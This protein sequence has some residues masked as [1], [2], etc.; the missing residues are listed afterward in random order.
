MS[1][2]DKL[3]GQQQRDLL[4]E[5]KTR[6][7]V[8]GKAFLK[9]G[10]LEI[11]IEIYPPGFLM[12]P[13]HAFLTNLARN[14][15]HTTP[16]ASRSRL[17]T[18]V[19]PSQPYLIQ[20]YGKLN[21][22]PTDTA[23]LLAEGRHAFFHKMWREGKVVDVR[24]FFCLT[25]GKK[26]RGKNFTYNESLLNQANIMLS[27]IMARFDELGYFPR[28]LT[29]QDIFE[30]CYAYY[31]PSL[32][33][34]EQK[35]YE[36]TYQVYADKILRE[37][38]SVRAPT[39]KAQ[40]AKSSVNNSYPSVLRVGEFF[41]RLIAM[42]S[43]PDATF[44]GL[45]NLLLQQGI[46]QIMV[47]DFTHLPHAQILGKIKNR[48]SR[49][50]AALDAEA[51]GENIELSEGLARGR[52]MLR[53][54]F[55]TG[56]HI[57]EVTSCVWLMHPDKDILR[58]KATA[59][60]SR[61]ANVPGNPYRLIDSGLLSP[62]LQCAPFSG[63]QYIERVTLVET[64]AAHFFP[65]FG[66]WDGSEK[67]MAMYQTRMGNLVGIDHFD[68]RNKGN[69]ALILGE[70]RSGKSFTMQYHMSEA[71]KDPNIEAVIIDRGLNW[72]RI[73]DVYDG[74]TVKIEPG[75]DTSINPFQLAEGET[76][77]SE[78]QKTLILQ[79]LLAMATDGQL[80]STPNEVA[81][82][83]AAIDEAYQSH[84]VAQEDPETGEYIDVAEIFTLSDFIYNLRNLSAIGDTPLSPQD[85][86]IAS[87]LATR[88]QL[89][90]GDSA[91][92]KFIDRPTQMPIDDAKVVLYE[93][94]AFEVI[95]AL[96]AVGTMLIQN[97]VWKRAL[98]TRE[99]RLIFAI[100]EAW[101]ITRNQYSLQLTLEIA[102]R[103]AKEGIS[104]WLL[105]HS[106]HDVTGEGK[107]AL[108]PAFDNYFLIRLTNEDN[109][110][111]EYM[112]LPDSYI[113]AFNNL[114]RQKGVFNEFLFMSRRD[115]G[116]E[117]EVLVLRPSPT[118]Y[119]TMTSDDEDL[120]ILARK[121]LELGSRQAAIRALAGV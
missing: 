83:T 41:L 103:G 20:E 56:D 82:L 81:I 61:M 78:D 26:I 31:N 85:K 88:F 110:L 75:G 15:L 57:F 50:A 89:W 24:H 105:T 63:D 37:N 90:A 47:T 118:D 22:A 104:M 58:Q 92:G 12:S 54:L 27:R 2:F 113:Q 99:K 76:K 6:D 87:D 115:T 4:S 11:G 46:Q 72:Q 68:Q 98:R 65:T 14:I 25:I 80:K 23:H 33:Q 53:H 108:L 84:L 79:L 1:F 45:N 107:E 100:D 17:I 112:K 3:F 10:R 95:P 13:D 64:N 21:H 86:A 119:W 94:S 93:T 111:R 102:R 59:T 7:V 73:V 69:H 116:L 106:L 120:K 74:V 121:E 91:L 48:N 16:E 70:P 117:A 114:S 97:E 29:T 77:P 36:S 60:L 38:N 18:V 5:I 49:A 67:P 62:W 42:T 32:T 9:D 34:V 96:S 28:Q 40:V 19:A 39:F 44:M 35:K 51:G 8:D 52:D 55:D 43:I 30:L 101:A 109:L 71:L 66:L